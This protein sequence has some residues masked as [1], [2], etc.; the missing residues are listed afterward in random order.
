MTEIPDPT[1][2][3]P[4][5]VLLAGI[6]RRAKEGFTGVLRADGPVSGIVVLRE[7][8]VV[9][10]ATPEAPGPEPLLLRSGRVAEADWTAA[11]AEGAPHGR[12]AEAL[13]AH[14]ALGALGV[15]VVAAT[16]LADAV[17][18]LALRGVQ[19][20]VAAP[21]DAAETGPL[22]FLDPGLAADDVVREAQ[23]RLAM[24]A[25]WQERGLT[26]TAVPASAAAG[27]ATDPLL[28]A[29]N[30]RRNVRGL[31]FALGRGLFA[32]MRSLADLMDA[33]A[34]TVSAEPGQA[35]PPTSQ[36]APHEPAPPEGLPKR[37]RGASDVIRVLPFRPDR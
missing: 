5:G 33:G 31:A 7:G 23:R 20:C 37:L 14:G 10:A 6:D 26:S 27:S 17:F 15:E 4:A 29:V 24:A 3:R 1:R 22:L 35:G 8:K 36:D 25:E 11:F 18:A 12:L 28:A 32:T 34:V 9:A 19:T 16:A 2:G 21:L 30:G 13:V